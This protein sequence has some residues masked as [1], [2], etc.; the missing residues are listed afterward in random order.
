MEEK[1][2]TF[3]YVESEKVDGKCILR[4]ILVHVQLHKFVPALF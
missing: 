2:H 1:Q 4:K 3:D